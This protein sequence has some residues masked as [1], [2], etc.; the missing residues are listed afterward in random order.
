MIYL[1]WIVVLVFWLYVLT[2][3]VTAVVVVMENRQPVKTMA[4][5]LVLLFLPVAGIVLF[6]FFGKDTRKEKYITQQ[7][8]DQL[9][10]RSIMGFAEQHDLVIPPQYEKLVSQFS[11]QKVALPFQDNE[12]HLRRRPPWASRQRCPYRQGQGRRGGE[13][14]LRRC[15]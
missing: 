3:V 9:S 13:G 4:W 10:K 1:H 14:H 12:V 7:S 5:L 11:T 6:I 15:G 2:V 8:L